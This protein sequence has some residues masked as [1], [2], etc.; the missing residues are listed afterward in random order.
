MR[1][2]FLA[3]ALILPA[4]SVAAADR[5]PLQTEL[6]PPL[7]VGTP[8]P[9]RL[10]NLEAKPA[11][12]PKVLVPAGTTNLAAGKPVTASDEEPLIGDASLITDGDKSAEEGAFVEFGP[13]KQWVQI[14]LEQAA[15]VHAVWLWHYHSQA[16][17]YLDVVVQLS[18]DPDFLE[19]VTTLFNNDHDN[20]SGLGAGKDPAYIETF[21]GRLV[22][23]PADGV[24][25]RYVRLYSAG[26]TIN[27]LNQYF[28]G[29][30][31]GVSAG[32]GR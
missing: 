19:G 22:P 10:P 18:N 8:V 30:V 13:G 31:F 29:E 5:I 20:S 25:A 23:A 14:D 7:L 3:V 12:P 21:R 6:P 26:N 11:E 32:G 1:T 4:L 9:V 27:P 28:A 24:K 15:T 16:R 2:S 17:A